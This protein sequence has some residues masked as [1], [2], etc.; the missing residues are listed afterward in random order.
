[1]TPRRFRRL[2]HILDHRQPTL[3]V[4]FD[5]LQKAHNVSAVVRTCDAVGVMEIHGI[6]DEESFRAKTTSSAGSDRFVDVRLHDDA[7]D[8]LGHLR[9]RD[10]RVWAA[11]LDERAVDFRS[12]DYT[13]PTCIVLGQEGPGVAEEVLERVDGTIAIP[14]VG[15][16]ESL[17]V[18]V[19]AA[20]ILFEAQR[21]RE[22]AGLYDAPQ[23]DEETRQRLLFEWGYRDLARYCRR[24]G[25]PYPRI[26]ED[27][28]MLDSIPRG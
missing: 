10:F 17:N 6:M 22:A 23:V 25:Y 2:S 24:K 16:V 14:M 8:A 18:S 26:G 15:A 19:A 5:D 11:H 4:L 27:G 13:E 20:V 7:E 9:R 28:E 3:T 1:M 21:Q 12:V